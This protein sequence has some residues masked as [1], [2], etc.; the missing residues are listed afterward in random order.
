MGDVMDETE[1]V[2]HPV[3]SRQV[4]V[5]ANV[6][7]SKYVTTYSWDD[8]ARTC[9]AKPGTVHLGS[10]ACVPGAWQLRLLERV[11]SKGGSGNEDQ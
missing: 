11:G 8:K 5:N 4:N 1:T 10:C 9:W 3:L 7:V 6:N 2:N